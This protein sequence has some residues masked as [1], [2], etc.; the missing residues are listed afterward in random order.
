MT[1]TPAE[2][3]RT[4]MRAVV[5]RR[6]GSPDVLELQEVEKPVL[7]DDRVLVRVRASSVNPA[8]YY[9]FRGSPF[10]AR[11]GMGLRRPKSLIQGTDLAGTV[12]AVGRNVTRFRL[13]DEVFGARSGA[14]AEYANPLE[15]RLALK[16]ANTTFEQA[17]AVPIAALTALQGL[18]DKGQIKPGQKVLI[19]GASGGV[20][21]FAVQIAKSFGAEVTAVCST[22]NV[23]QTRTL[24]A[25]HVVDYSQED[26]AK[27]EFRYDL[28]LD[29]AGNRSL[30]DLR[31]VL[32]SS[33]TLV[34]VGADPTIRGGWVRVFARLAKAKML[35]WFAGQKIIFFIAKIN[36]GDLTV[37]KDLIE[38]GKVT[39][40]IDRRYP[41]DQVSVAMRYLGERHARAKVVLT[42]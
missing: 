15:D 19:N 32:V 37:M 20:G 31:R 2:G 13:G 5:C 17:A 39:P 8:D 4:T 35:S 11:F 25:D 1:E 18:R 14:F 26:F 36:R 9:S 29:V 33:G 24:G 34:L 22:G 3:S 40:L 38:A 10:V 27:G 7:G 30:A 16:P 23:E 41:I 12:E 6:Y 42:I 21:T 28:V